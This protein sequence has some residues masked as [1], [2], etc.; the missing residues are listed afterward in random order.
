MRRL[1]AAALGAGDRLLGA[2]LPSNERTPEDSR[3]RLGESSTARTTARAIGG[4]A[5]PD[6][7]DVG[8]RGQRPELRQNPSAPQGAA[9]CW[10]ERLVSVRLLTFDGMP[11]ES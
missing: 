10:N 7:N 9:T 5:V 1:K 4:G 3:R 11:H 6:A 2:N 8:L